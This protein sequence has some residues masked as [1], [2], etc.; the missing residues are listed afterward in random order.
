M[1]ANGEPIS[2]YQGITTTLPQ[3]QSYPWPP[4]NG[5]CPG[6]GRC[7]DCGR[8]YE[9]QPYSPWPGYP[10][11]Y[12]GDVPGWMQ[13]GPTCGTLTSV[14]SPCTMAG[15]IGADSAQPQY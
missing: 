10:N 3:P 7:R 4:N 9:T 6:C 1:P 12:I 5:V 15:G 14:N 8:P 13:W 2:Y 11:P